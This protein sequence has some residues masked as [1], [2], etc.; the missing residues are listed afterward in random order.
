MI[1]KDNFHLRTMA[2][3]SEC[4]PIET[5]PDY[6]SFDKRGNVSSRY[7]YTSQGVIRCSDHWGRVASC[8]WTL[9]G[10]SKSNKEC[11]VYSK[12][13][14][15]FCSFEDFNKTTKKFEQLV[16]ERM[17]KLV[18]FCETY[19][20]DNDIEYFGFL[21]ANKTAFGKELSKELEENLNELFET[22]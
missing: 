15:G 14:F 12:E 7:W 2:V 20:K 17:R 4:S 9:K 21:E 19:K 16:D 18:E 5:T 8:I 6:V 3:Y 10:K 22:K 11:E 13:Y 1:N